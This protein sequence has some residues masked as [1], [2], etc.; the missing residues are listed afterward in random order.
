MKIVLPIEKTSEED[1]IGTSFGRTEYF[2]L[3]DSEK[4]ETVITDNKAAMQQ[5]GAGIKAAQTVIDMHADVVI[6]PQCG[7]NAMDL[8]IAAKVTV[9]KSI[10]RDVLENIEKCLNN[11]LEV[12]N[13]PHPGLHHS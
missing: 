2:M 1:L 5:G 11:Q 9:L 10:S 12:L 13:D 7:Q 4:D 3:F 6:L 8:F